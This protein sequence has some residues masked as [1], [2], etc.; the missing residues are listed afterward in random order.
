[1]VVSSIQSTLECPQCGKHS[2]VEHQSGVY[3]CLSC[4]FE[5]NLDDDRRDKMPNSLSV[6]F[7]ALGFVL[8]V[9][10]L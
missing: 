1:M 10:A 7:G 4:D 5:K 8:L 9:L 6:I 3:V 2:V